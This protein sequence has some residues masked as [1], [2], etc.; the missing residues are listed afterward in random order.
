MAKTQT[1]L[2]LLMIVDL[3]VGCSKCNSPTT[4]LFGDWA[5]SNDF[6][7]EARSEAVIFTIGDS[8]YVATGTTDRQKFQDLWKYDLAQQYWVQLANLPG[9]ARASAVAFSVGNFGY[10]ASGVDGDGNAL[11]DVY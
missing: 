11:N 1:L 7:G 8:A 6:D 10:V 9:P 4:T 2:F 3:M 5:R